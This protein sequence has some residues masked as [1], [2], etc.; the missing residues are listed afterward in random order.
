M[1][2]AHHCLSVMAGLFSQLVM[3]VVEC[4]A[5]ETKPVLCRKVHIKSLEALTLSIGP[6]SLSLYF[7]LAARQVG[8]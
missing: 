3:L 2:I 7:Y 5:S 4:K 6:V 8:I 1:M